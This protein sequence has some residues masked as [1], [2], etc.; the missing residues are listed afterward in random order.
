MS[1]HANPFTVGLFVLGALVLA[2]AGAV[3]LSTVRL[4]GPDN[5]FVIYFNESVRGLNIGSPVAYRGVT[6]GEVTSIV[7]GYSLA[8]KDIVA[9]PVTIRIDPSRVQILDRNG[10][11]DAQILAQMVESGLRAQ[12]QLQSLVTAQLFIA[13]DF[14]PGQAPRFQHAGGDGQLEIPSV[15]SPLAAIQRSIDEVTMA[16]PELL[17]EVQDIMRL[18]R[19]LLAG[20]TGEDVRRAIRAATGLARRLGDPDGPLIP[21]LE[22]LPALQAKLAT[23]LDE[24]S[25]LMAEATALTASLQ[26]K[27]EARD[28]QVGELVAELTRTAASARRAADQAGTL[29]AQ[30]R[31]AVRTFTSRGLP[32]LQGM[33]QDANRMVNEL[34]GL[35]RDIR[36]DPAR[37]FFG[38]QTREGIRL[39]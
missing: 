8:R 22:Q 35:V 31:D 15:P 5:E 29:I 38:D 27:V 30:N 19:E 24:A 4:F 7:A 14:F 34:N 21:V 9:V 32:E 13:L 36:Q 37:F 18:V 25:A 33:I 23:T 1:R 2:V 17:A 28:E 20:E 26:G 11:T 3:T 6:V 12:L 16:T 10:A 39:R